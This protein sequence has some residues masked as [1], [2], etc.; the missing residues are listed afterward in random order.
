MSDIYHE[1]LQRQFKEVL[2]FG[3]T[4][5]NYHW[6]DFKAWEAPSG[7]FY[8]FTDSGCSCYTFGEG[9][10]GAADFMDGDIEALERA[11]KAWA[12][13]TG[14]SASDHIGNLGKLRALRSRR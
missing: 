6:E 4:D 9:F 3:D 12:E 7:R 13:E 2:D 11:Y 8:W 10:N 1:A 14:V 5:D